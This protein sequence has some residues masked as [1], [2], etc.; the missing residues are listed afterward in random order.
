MTR[1]FEM[2][3]ISSLSNNSLNSILALEINEIPW[4]MIDWAISTCRFP[5]ISEFFL[6]SRTISTLVNY[7]NDLSPWSTWPSMHRGLPIQEHGIYALGQDIATYKG[8]PIW[9][10]LVSLGLSV[11]IFGPLQSWPPRDPGKFGFYLPD[12]FAQT[13]EAIPKSLEAFQRFNLTMVKKSGRV[14]SNNNMLESLNLLMRSRPTFQMYAHILRHLGL[15]SVGY[16]GKESR[17]TLQ[18]QITWDLFKRYYNA[19]SHSI[20]YASWFTNHIA[21]VLHRY[22]NHIFPL[23]YSK[24][25]SS[26]SLA[27][28]RLVFYAFSQLDLVLRD[29]MSIAKRNSRI[30][31]VLSS[32]MSQE[33]VTMSSRT[34]VSLICRDLAKFSSTLWGASNFATPNLA[35]VPQVSF[36]MPDISILSSYKKILA[37]KNLI[38]VLEHGDP[39]PLISRFDS[40]GVSLSI[41]LASRLDSAPLFIQDSQGT[42]YSLNDFGIICESVNSPSAYHCPEGVLAIYGNKVVPESTRDLIIPVENYSTLIKSLI[43]NREDVSTLIGNLSLK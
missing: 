13:P 30:T 29:A 3:P 11:G 33:P 40:Y 34:E 20:S 22:W 42:R 38:C 21:S 7:S 28:L 5:S 4:T 10:E 9:D 31:I 2:N 12:T 39:I 37:G 32:S 14:P 43:F 41:S 27:K 26:Q 1:V 15:E 23:S 35:M 19:G 6:N 25:L 16:I 36:G 18:S 24:P 17:T 8:V